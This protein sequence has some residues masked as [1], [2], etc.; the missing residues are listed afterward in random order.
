MPSL[1]GSEMC[2]RDSITTNNILVIMGGNNCK[3][4][5]W[6]GSECKCKNYKC[7]ASEDLIKEQ[8]VKGGLAQASDLNENIFKLLNGNKKYLHYV[9][10]K[11]MLGPCITC[12]HTPQ[13]HGISE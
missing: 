4:K 5:G 6:L 9:M 8:L 7:Q 2:I 1:V 3:H 13:D 11:C 10:Q 12:T